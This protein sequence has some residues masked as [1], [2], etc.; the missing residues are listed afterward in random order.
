MSA[1][2]KGPHLREVARVPVRGDRFAV[3]G[4]QLIVG[5]LHAEPPRELTVVDVSTPDRAEVKA[6]LP[7]KYPISVVQLVGDVVYVYEYKR[8]IHL[9][10]MDGVTP[11]RFD[12]HLMFGKDVSILAAV[13]SHWLVAARKW[14]GIVSVLDVVDP[15][16]PIETDALELGTSSV[17]SLVVVGDRVF[18]A[19]SRSGLVE[20]RIDVNGKLIEVA[21]WFGGD[22]FR[23][24][25]VFAIG[26][27]LWVFGEGTLPYE[28]PADG[29]AGEPADEDPDEDTDDYEY[30]EAN[31]EPNTLIFSL[32]DVGG[33][34]AWIGTNPVRP[35]HL[36]PMVGGGAI[37][38]ES[39]RCWHFPRAEKAKLLFERWETRPDGNGADG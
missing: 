28:P 1:V 13:G 21:R 11:V 33:A 39:Y 35:A 14:Q 34:P 2:F 15:T 19:A 23:V 30:E 36:S 6:K 8:A 20:L 25:R 10:R 31:Q 17:E 22:R 29:A 9:V 27:E 18:V 32:E 37:A 16:R 3:R 24:D 5:S 7:F 26:G 4:N 12:C 38:L